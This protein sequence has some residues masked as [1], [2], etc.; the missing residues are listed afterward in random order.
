M[1]IATVQKQ[2]D[3]P[4]PM[5]IRNAPTQ[6][7]KNMNYGK[8]YQYSHMG[9]GNFIP[10]EYLPDKIAGTKFYEPGNNA[11]EQELRKFLKERWKDKYNY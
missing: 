10:Q 11:R 5:H 1:A 7:M 4:V 9:E 8:G 6:L 3:L 2:G